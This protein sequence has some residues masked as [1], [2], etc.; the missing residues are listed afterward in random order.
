MFKLRHL[1]FCYVMTL[2]ANAAGLDCKR[3]SL[4]WSQQTYGTYELS[5]YAPPV[6][7]RISA[8]LLTYAILELQKLEGLQARTE[9]Q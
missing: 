7:G 5:H 9:L 4:K 6:I 8:L 2:W 3:D 1:T